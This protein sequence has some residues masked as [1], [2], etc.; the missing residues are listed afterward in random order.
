MQ[1]NIGGKLY[2]TEGCYNEYPGVLMGLLG[3]TN[4]FLGSNLMMHWARE[5][6]D[7][8]IDS[9]ATIMIFAG[10]IGSNIGSYLSYVVVNLGLQR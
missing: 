10:I 1:T 7:H 3:F 4:G 9:G 5:V 2:G 6:E 8:H